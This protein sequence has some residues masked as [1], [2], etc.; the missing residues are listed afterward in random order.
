MLMFMLVL[1]G[2]PSFKSARDSKRMVTGSC[3][4]TLADVQKH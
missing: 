3:S 1:E 4:V 2:C